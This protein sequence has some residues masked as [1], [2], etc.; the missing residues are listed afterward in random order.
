MLAPLAEILGE[1]SGGKTPLL[2][3]FLSEV[4]GVVECQPTSLFC[5]FNAGA[6]GR[7]LF[8]KRALAPAFARIRTHL[9]IRRE[10]RL[11]GITGFVEV[12]RLFRYLQLHKT[13]PAPGGLTRSG[14]FGVRLVRGC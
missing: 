13:N 14:V 4:L 8:K 12:T 2:G 9:A 1:T 11:S 10:W 3:I 6:V 7:T 5:C